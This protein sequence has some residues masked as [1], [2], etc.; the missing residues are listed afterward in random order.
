MV[1]DGRLLSGVTE[2]M[3][4]VE[5]GSMTRADGGAGGS[6]AELSNVCN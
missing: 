3:A 5:A 2:L 4:V 1:Y 6:A